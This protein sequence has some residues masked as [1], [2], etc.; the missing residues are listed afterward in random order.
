MIKNSKKCLP[1]IIGMLIMFPVFI[2]PSMQATINNNEHDHDEC[3]PDD[4]LQLSFI[5]CECGNPGCTGNI[6]TC[7]WS[8]GVPRPAPTLTQPPS[9]DEDGIITLTWTSAYGANSYKVYR[10]DAEFGTYTLIATTSILAY[11]DTKT[12]GIWWYY[13]RAH[14]N[15][16]DSAA[17]NKVTVEVI[18]SSG[19]TW[20]E[21][22]EV[23][24]IGDFPANE[25]N[26]DGSGSVDNIDVVWASN[27]NVDMWGKAIKLYS[28]SY[29]FATGMS[30][31][32]TFTIDTGES[33][34][35]KFKAQ[36]NKI[37]ADCEGKVILIGNSAQTFLGIT[38]DTYW[39]TLDIEFADGQI[40]SYDLILNQV[41]D[42][43]IMFIKDPITN[44]L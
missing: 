21:S 16:G 23:Y 20:Y 22:N 28:P 3:D 40:G 29:G 43:A 36:I 4:H 25:W 10:S 30:R 11:T 18:L 19:V 42:F 39:E 35:L 5:P 24:N 15:N 12:E 27:Y 32:D 44:N 17:G 26:P 1:L 37:A 38:F 9:P 2:L 8:L 14:N 6:Q 33:L 34:Y 41:Y 13:V 31:F 7:P